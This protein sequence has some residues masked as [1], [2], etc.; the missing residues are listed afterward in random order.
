VL[1]EI[2]VIKEAFERATGRTSGG[3]VGCYR[4]DGAATAVVA[5]GSVIGSVKDVV[6]E[7]REQGVPIGVVAVSCYRPWPLDEVRAALAGLERVIVL[8]RAF[9][10]GSGTMLGQDVRLTL[11]TSSARVHDVV[12]GLGGR[13]VTRSSIRSLVH[14]VLGGEVDPDRLHFLDLDQDVVARELVASQVKES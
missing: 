2:P 13:P 1:D 8:N 11:A 5:M 3:L 6:D 10:V 7:L 9:A 14:A 4:M 12:A